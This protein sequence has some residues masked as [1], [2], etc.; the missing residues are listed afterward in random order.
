MKSLKI[1]HLILSVALALFFIYAGTKKFIPRSKSSKPDKNIELIQ[2]VTT[3]F[4]EN[5]ITFQL[6][7]KML[8]TTGFLK[9]VGVLQILAGLLILFPFT[10]LVGLITLLPITINIFCFHL[11]MDNR[12]GENLETGLYLLI[13]CLLIV[14]YYKTISTL[15]K[16]KVA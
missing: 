1:P 8:K 3:N 4:Y 5:P 15:F 2:S 14:A 7:V 12:I 16:A 10:R 11:F 9:M 13:N 6:C